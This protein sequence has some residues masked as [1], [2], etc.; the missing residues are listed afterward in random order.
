MGLSPIRERE[1]VAFNR[2]NI[3][4]VTVSKISAVAARSYANTWK[5]SI[6]KSIMSWEHNKS[7]P[8]ANS[9][10]LTTLREKWMRNN[11]T[12]VARRRT[13]KK[14]LYASFSSQ[15]HH[16]TLWVK[17]TS[18]DCFDSS[19][20]RRYPFHRQGPWRQKLLTFI[21]SWRPTFVTD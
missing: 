4:G 6:V 20:R 19:H 21:R 14:S 9:H 5:M 16:G 11:T 7:G 2:C 3:C 17:N 18:Y 8:Q 13:Q 1:Q 10:W 12:L 15:P